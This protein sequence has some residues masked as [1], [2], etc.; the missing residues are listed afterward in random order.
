[1]K[2]SKCGAD[3]REGQRFCT[4]C[5]SPLTAKCPRCG[6]A[7]EPG[8]KFC[9][10][11]G[12]ALSNN[13][14][15][16]YSPPSPSSTSETQTDTGQI[17]ESA[18]SKGERRHLTV[19][20]CDLVNSTEIAARLDPEEWRDV[21]ARYQHVAAQAVARFD[22]HVAQYLGDGVLALFGYPAAHE[23]DAE[24]A[25]RTGLKIIEGVSALNAGFD[26]KALPALAA[27]V[28]IHAGPVVVGNPDN[29]SA[30]VF[31][32]TPNMAAR[33]QAAAERNT[34]VVSAA[35]H[36]LVSGRFVVEDRG[37]HT[38]KGI[39]HPVQL[40]QI[41]RP[42]GMR[43]RLAAA[44]ATGA[45]TPFV[46]RQDELRLLMSCWER[47]REGEGQVVTIVGEA[48]IGKSRLVQEF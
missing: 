30:N 9:G 16:M 38:L 41:I 12:G 36:Q 3:N 15:G 20:F 35:V 19:L 43:G 39:A 8:E 5:G 28:G 29:K 1:M 2:C 37:A 17:G 7:T 11:C 22:G 42:S 48:G 47:A 34:V 27:R 18:P 33:V 24:R 46:G 44:A 23:N 21:I 6:A 4:Q 10:A 32:E 25:V 26:S 13:G 45:L 14:V 40:Y 31:G